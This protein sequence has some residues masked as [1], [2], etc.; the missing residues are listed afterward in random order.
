MILRVEDT[1]QARSTAASEA[2][3][4]RDL[5]WLGIRW[6]EGPDVGGPYGPYRQSERGEI[7][8]TY[9][10]KLAE[11]GR[12][13]PCFC[14]DEELEAMRTEAEEK[15]LPPLY[16]GKWASQDPEIVQEATERIAKGDP[17][18]WRFR[19]P[20]DES[21]SLPDAVRGM[22]QWDTNTLGDFILVRSSGIPVYNYCATI[23]DALM[24]IT[25]VIRAEEHLPNT[26]KQLLIYQA[27]DFPVCVRTVPLCR[28]AVQAPSNASPV[29]FFTFTFYWLVSF[30][31]PLVQAPTFAHCS[32]ILAPDRSKL[33]KRH[34][35]T[36]VG[37]FAEM[38]VLP[39]AMFNFLTL[40][41]WNDGTEQ[42]IFDREEL[43]SKFSLDRVS[44]SP[45]VFDLQKMKW[46][47]SQHMKKM[48][49]GS[50]H[51][52]IVAE[53]A[54]AE[55][56]SPSSSVPEELSDKESECTT[57]VVEMIKD[58]LE[59]KADAVEELKLILS[60][61]LD[62][63]VAKVSAADQGDADDDSGALVAKEWIENGAVATLGK[64][65]VEAQRSG[66]LQV[67]SEGAW[68]LARP[69][70]TRYTNVP[71]AFSLLRASFPRH[72][73][74]GNKR[75]VLRSNTTYTVP[76]SSLYFMCEI[77]F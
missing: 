52:A 16:N 9:L 56:L 66:E 22:V 10:D 34:G 54:K 44:K 63:T 51:D 30:I 64:L 40:L 24:K 72:R 6:D 53:W 19:V 38:G 62:E 68:V 32:L 37:Q 70:T 67:G 76:L 48:D 20:K 13:Y 36:S 58:S 2:A 60:Y 49:A 50:L 65:L 46:M 4:L 17:H 25:H 3:V 74:H 14:T 15:G 41:G 28:L 73:K 42:E 26:L 31:S 12:A 43:G 71:I 1:D 55:L 39:D 47:N 11:L 45:A 27:L 57:M 8:R 23:D 35:A 33:S 18:A 77:G 75:Q 59:T 61:P 7:Y 69:E 5:S 29:L 21:I